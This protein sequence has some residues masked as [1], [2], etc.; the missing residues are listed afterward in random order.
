MA[1]NAHAV[2]RFSPRQW[3]LVNQIGRSTHRPGRRVSPLLSDYAPRSFHFE[4]QSL[5]PRDTKNWYLDSRYKLIETREGTSILSRGLPTLRR[6][7]VATPRAAFFPPRGKILRYRAIRRSTAINEYHETTR[8]ATDPSCSCLVGSGDFLAA[9]QIRSGRIGPDINRRGGSAVIL[10]ALRRPTCSTART[11]LAL[12]RFSGPSGRVNDASVPMAR[13]VSAVA[14]RTA[15]ES[16]RLLCGKWY[17]RET[18]QP[19]A[20]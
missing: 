20:P 12:F 11:P 10:E 9:R 2:A 14:T 19:C 4:L 18:G 3:V 5:S 13:A 17:E 8:A 16:G 15:A 1:I 7:R 6:S